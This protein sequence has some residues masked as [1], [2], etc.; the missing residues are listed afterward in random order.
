MTQTTIAKQDRGFLSALGRAVN[1]FMADAQDKAADAA[2][3]GAEDLSAVQ[4]AEKRLPD[5]LKDLK[6][7]YVPTVSQARLNALSWD[8]PDPVAGILAAEVGRIA[9]EV[10]L[11]VREAGF[12]LGSTDKA[13]RRRMEK[14]WHKAVAEMHSSVFGGMKLPVF[15]VFIDG[16]LAFELM[17]E[18]RAGGFVTELYGQQSGRLYLSR[19]TLA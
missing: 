17:D 2:R 1:G 8:Y 4:L 10:G 6:D 19:R 7:G 16:V 3:R 13:L 15:F 12:P 14:T 11:L 9:D 18:R 5:L